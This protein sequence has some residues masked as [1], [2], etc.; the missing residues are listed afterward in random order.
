MMKGSE[1]ASRG[2][3]WLQSVLE[4]VLRH[5]QG[6]IHGDEGLVQT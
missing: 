3:V 2:L 4:E 6:E 5:H 1:Q